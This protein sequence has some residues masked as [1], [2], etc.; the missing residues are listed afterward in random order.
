MARKKTKQIPTVLTNPFSETSARL[1]QQRSV[2]SMLFSLEPEW[3]NYTK[4]YNAINRL[5]GKLLTDCFNDTQASLTSKKRSYLLTRNEDGSLDL[6][7]VQLGYPEKT[8][9]PDATYVC[10]VTSKTVKLS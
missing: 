1:V 9:E 8:L 3:E 7:D 6:T 2:S 4:S 10:L 5:Q